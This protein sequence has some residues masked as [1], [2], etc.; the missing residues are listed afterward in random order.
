MTAHLSDHELRRR[1]AAFVDDVG[2]D[3]ARDLC[4]PSWRPLLDALLAA[5][6]TARK[7]AQTMTQTRY[8]VQDAP[9]RDP[10]Q[11][12]AET[13]IA[14]DAAGVRALLAEA[15]T[16]AERQADAGDLARLELEAARRLLGDEP[17]TRLL[18]QALTAPRAAQGGA[19]A[20]KSGPRSPV[21][22]IAAQLAAQGFTG[23]GAAGFN[24]FATKRGR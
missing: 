8:K 2:P 11:A 14:R 5:R 6:R 3:A 19:A 23:A 9:P 1:I 24:P 12:L 7:E 21:A 15:T 13:L 18:R 22:Q 20:T 17:V 10:V 4:P 16:A